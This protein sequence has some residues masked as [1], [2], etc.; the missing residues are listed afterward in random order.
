MTSRRF[1][2]PANVKQSSLG[3]PGISLQTLM[4][5]ILQS[6]PTRRMQPHSRFLITSAL[7]WVRVGSSGVPNGI[8]MGRRCALFQFT[9]S[10][11]ISSSL[12]VPYS[13]RVGGIKTPPSLLLPLLFDIPRASPS[14][15]LSP[16]YI[17][18]GFHPSRRASPPGSSRAC[19][20]RSIPRSVR[21]W[22]ASS[23]PRSHPD[24]IA[25]P[26]RG[27]VR[28]WLVAKGIVAQVRHFRCRCPCRCTNT[29]GTH[30]P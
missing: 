25:K 20:S 18:T 17:C 29:T 1:L 4:T 16:Q 30:W 13:I 2:A 22:A 24:A 5:Y 15:N 26:G 19:E 6:V 7:S 8:V 11:T 12:S 21:T 14:S 3:L 10:C 27:S 23:P 9:M 28:H